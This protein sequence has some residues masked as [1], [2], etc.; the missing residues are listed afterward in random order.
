MPPK[1]EV[2]EQVAGTGLMILVDV[3]KG[4][5]VIIRQVQHL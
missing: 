3:K 4:G 5:K 2:M 1:R